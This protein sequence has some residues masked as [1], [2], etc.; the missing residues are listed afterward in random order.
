MK[1]YL[2]GVQVR[3]RYGGRSEM[4]LWRRQKYDPTFPR[5]VVVGRLKHYAEDELDAY[6]DEHRRALPVAEEA[7]A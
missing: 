1:R 5:P 7:I 3:A 2:T 4:W 6:D